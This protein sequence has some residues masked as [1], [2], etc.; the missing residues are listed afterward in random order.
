MIGI[1]GF[2]EYVERFEYVKIYVIVL[3]YLA[4]V[5]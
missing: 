5:R 4:I 2:K 1:Y 3:K